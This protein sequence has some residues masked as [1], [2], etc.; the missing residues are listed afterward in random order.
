LEPSSACHLPVPVLERG[1]GDIFKKIPGWTFPRGLGVGNL[2][3]DVGLFGS[4]LGWLLASAVFGGDVR[5]ALQEPGATVRVTVKVCSL[6]GASFLRTKL[7]LVE[8]SEVEVIEPTPPFV[9]QDR[10]RHRAQPVE[11]R[12]AEG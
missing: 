2:L 8:G 12:R 11:M 5:H 3:E 1:I 7:E 9:R 6:L 10:V 4:T